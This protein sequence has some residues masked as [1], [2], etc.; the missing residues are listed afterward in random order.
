MDTYHT[1]EQ[2]ECL[3]TIARENGFFWQTLW[4]HPQNAQLKRE[5]QNPNV[6]LPGDL[7]YIPE[8]QEKAFDR[9]TEKRHKFKV[10]GAPAKL[11]LQ[12]MH[13]GKPRANL[14]Y[15]LIIDGQSFSGATNGEGRLEHVIPPGA[16]SGK[17]VLGQGK[18]EY[19][20]NLGHLDPVEK[21]TG[22]QARLNNLGYQCGEVDGVFGPRTQAA[23]R[24]FQ[25][26]NSSPATGEPDAATRRKLVEA[27]GS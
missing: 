15:V 11:R 21:L 17:L 27:H 6:L 2:G 7:L 24:Q 3:L 5:R 26:E 22:L 18:E 1:V 23:L 13:F 4:D 10:K 20:L 19:R 25:E 14:R 12:L 8:K 9:V 16:R